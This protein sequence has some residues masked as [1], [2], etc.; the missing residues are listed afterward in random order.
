V[1]DD[2]SVVPFRFGC[3][4]LPHLAEALVLCRRVGELL[5]R[6]LALEDG[7]DEVDVRVGV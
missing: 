7:G 3:K 6:A 1:V 4:K 2:L 5:V